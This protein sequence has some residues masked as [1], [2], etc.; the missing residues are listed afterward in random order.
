MVQDWGQW[1]AVMSV[2]IRP[3]SMKGGKYLMFELDKRLLD[4]E[5]RIMIFG[6]K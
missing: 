2:V 6:M 4:F 3:R 5:K 1:A